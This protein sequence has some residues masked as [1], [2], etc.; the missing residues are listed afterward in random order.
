[1]ALLKSEY[2]G[3]GIKAASNLTLASHHRMASVI[4]K[5]APRPAKPAQRHFAKKGPTAARDEDN[6][7]EEEQEQATV[8]QASDEEIGTFGQEFTFV[9]SNKLPGKGAR[10]V[11]VALGNVNV[12]DGRVLVDGQADAGKEIGQER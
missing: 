7:S 5:A 8:E 10:T 6:S 11:K 1:M 4:R 2:I 9:S 3:L 12:K